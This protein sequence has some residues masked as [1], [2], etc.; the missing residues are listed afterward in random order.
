MVPRVAMFTTAGD[1]RLTMGASEGIGAASR[2]RGAVRAPPR[3]RQAPS[4]GR[5]QA[6]AEHGGREFETQSHALSSSHM[7]P[8]PGGGTGSAKHGP[9]FKKSGPSGR[10]SRTAILHRKSALGGLS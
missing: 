3:E 5:E 4:A 1:T 2:A 8:L 6:G 7:D 10:Y 9:D